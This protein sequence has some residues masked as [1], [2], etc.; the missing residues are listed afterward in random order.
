MITWDTSW[1]AKRYNRKRQELLVF[2]I[3]DDFY[4]I[5]CKFWQMQIHH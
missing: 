4:L 2:E 5:N 3:P 1:T